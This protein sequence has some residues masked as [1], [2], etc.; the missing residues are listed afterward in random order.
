MK[1]VFGLTRLAVFLGFK[2]PSVTSS[3]DFSEGPSVDEREAPSFLVLGSFICDRTRFGFLNV[4]TMEEVE[5]LQWK[6]CSS[7]E[8]VKMLS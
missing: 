6:N 3:M 8:V 1:G 4:C 2:K 7:S 5:E